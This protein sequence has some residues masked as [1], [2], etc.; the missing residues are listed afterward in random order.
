MVPVA[1]TTLVASTVPQFDLYVRHG[2]NNQMRLF[3]QRN[4]PFTQHGIEMLVARGIHTLYVLA[5]DS[6]AYSDYLVDSVVDDASIPPVARYQAL[7][8]TARVL[9]TDALESKNV[10]KVVGT[11]NG[12]AEQL[13]L[14]VCGSR[15][16]LFD[17]F[18][19]MAHDY[20]T[21][22]HMM[23]VSTYCMLLAHSIGIRDQAEL[24]EIGQGALLHDIGKLEIS[25]ATLT[26]PGKLTQHEAQ[27][28]RE[29]PTRGFRKLAPGKDLS[30][31]QLMMVYQ[32]H[33]RCDGRGYPANL[34]RSEIHDWARLC[35]IVDVFDALTNDRHYRSA[36][37]L[38]DVLEYFDVQA[39][40][41]FDEEMVHC[42]IALVTNRK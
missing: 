31:G 5:A 2:E 17:L 40:R 32:H 25:A 33:E 38:A 10:D 7:R 29:H 19:V 13:V 9:L 6:K 42:L 26:K 18:Q 24:I 15:A 39:G 30:W 21:F 23:N 28:L 3:R 34:L 37:M 8:E 35:A 36:A 20:S 4:Y 11:T 14:T 22:A 41:G 1:V 16:R 12:V 27:I